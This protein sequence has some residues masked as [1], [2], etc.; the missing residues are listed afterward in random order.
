MIGVIGGMGPEA[1]VDLMRRVI[2]KT[3]AQ[4]DADHIHLIVESNPKIASR[5]AH[6]LDRTGPDPT[7][8]LMR[9]ARNLERAGADALAMPCNT[10]HAYADAIRG[11]VCIPL[12]NM[13]ELTADRLAA[14]SPGARVGLL[15]TSAVH[16]MGL[17]EQAL[18]RRG[19]RA[20]VPAEQDTTMELI[21]AVKQGQTGVAIRLRL[22]ELARRFSGQ[23][24][25]LLIACT[26]LSAIS[27]DIDSVF[28]D[29]ADV[30]TNAIL[31][32]AGVTAAHVGNPPAK[33]TS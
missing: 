32:F 17:Y 6:L 8:E 10:A 16:R 25:V 19:L 21:K 11:S 26:D 33:R 12:L 28:V 20:V 14:Q 31:K 29:A 24:D 7:P 22:A 15:A 2:A 23:A 9:I 5:L 30:L 18:A 1:T 4:D 27:S 3:P 13:V